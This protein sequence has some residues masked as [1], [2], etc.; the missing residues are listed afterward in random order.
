MLRRLSALKSLLPN[1]KICQFP[2][3]IDSFFVILIDIKSK[4][5]LKLG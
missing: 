2:K 5:C 3:Q 1:Q 4:E